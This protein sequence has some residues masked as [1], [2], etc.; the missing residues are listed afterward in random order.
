MN[1]EYDYSGLYNNGNDQPQ[2]EVPVQP[3][4]PS[5]PVQ[6]AQSAPYTAQAAPNPQ[7]AGA[8]DG[9]PNVGSTGINTANTAPTDFGASP[10]PAQNSYTPP[11][12]SYA[13]NGGYT[14]SFGGNGGNGGGYNGYSYASA[15]QQ[16]PKKP[17]KQGSKIGLRIAAAVGVVALGFG[18]G[19]GGMMV[20]SRLGLGGSQVV[21]QTVERNTDTA[22]IS[23]GSAGGVSLSLQDVSAIVQ[24]SVVAITTEQ[25]V[26][27]NAWFGNYVQSGAGSGVIISQDGY[28]LTCAHV[29]SGA[30]NI[31][32]QLSDD[33]E[34]TATLVGG[35]ASADIAVLKVEA[36][37][38]TPAVI[39]DSD[40][41]VVGETAIACGNPLGTLG[42]T[43][44]NGI[45]SAVNRSI[46]VDDNQMNLVQ[47]NASISPGNS[48]GGLFNGNG[49]LIGIV[50]AKSG[51]T[52]AEGLG[53]AIPINTA[54][55]LAQEII[56]NGYVKRPALGVTVVSVTD[57]STA[58]QYGVSS[59]GVYIAQVNSGSGAESAGLQVADR[60]VAVNDTIVSQ[61]SDLTNYLSDLSVGDTVTVQVEREGK[62]LSVEVVL[63]EG[64]RG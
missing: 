50:N 25:V 52:Q 28:I 19:L 6:P 42:G 59:L 64:S 17:K 54:M 3:A 57:S 18:G 24:P 22:A 61:S 4:A 36:T 10:N 15:P 39:G 29:V 13:G 55:E 23:Q 34:Y 14:S 43:V 31:I 20:G 40:A 44:T 56:S 9:Y 53:F 46:T 45:I 37:G 26:S 32:V 16:P 47:T 1:N 49:E 2:P 33:T 48:G 21:V 5:Q 62:L 58:M 51:Y 60:I 11:Q 12:S 7:P 41:L 27:S 38:L 8:A 30:S 35:D 63:G